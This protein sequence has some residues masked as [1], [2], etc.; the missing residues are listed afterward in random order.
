MSTKQIQ[1]IQI[2]QAF[3][4]AL[5]QIQQAKICC[6][7]FPHILIEQLFPSSFY[8]HLL[9]NFPSPS[10]FQK[11]VYPGTGFAK[12]NRTRNG[13][14]NYG[15]V[16]FD[17]SSSPIFEQVR[18]FLKSE[19]FMNALL[20]KFSQPLPSGL[21]PIP[22]EK[23]IFFRDKVLECTSV[24]DLHIDLPGYEIAPHPDVS[25]KI[26]TYQF[27]LVNTDVLK[28]FGTLLCQPKGDLWGRLALRLLNNVGKLLDNLA[29]KLRINKTNFYQNFQQ[30]KLGFWLNL[31][32]PNWAPWSLFNI[33]KVMPALP[34]H[35]MAFSPNKNSYHAVRLDIPIDHEVQQR[36]V[37]RGFIR[38][39]VNEQNWV[40]RVP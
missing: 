39:G 14:K 35:F 10:H 24:C 31:N 34:N 36:P 28:D 13:L 27:F 22:A 21:I 19:A 9:E 11:A 3:E 2:E 6:E 20:T 4:Y 29:K 23:H 25:S 33:T 12:T 18:D 16:C 5:T 8:D 7:P 40:K 38:S 32:H 17:L 15:L 26:V 37:I 30:S 1:P